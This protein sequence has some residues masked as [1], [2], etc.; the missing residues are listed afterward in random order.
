M[1]LTIHYTDGSSADWSYDED[2]SSFNGYSVSLDGNQYYA[3]PWQLGVNTVTVTY[4]GAETTFAVEVVESPVASIEVTKLPDKPW[5]I[6]NF[7][8]H[9][10]TRWDENLQEQVLFVILFSRRNGD[11]NHYTDGT[12]AIWNADD[13]L[14]YNGYY[15]S[16]GE[17]QYTTPGIGINTATVAYMG[18]QTTLD[19]VIETLSRTSK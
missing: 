16:I 14:F 12:S 1:E 7:N 10:D 8:G 18:A 2:G 13:G 15:I 17:N 3:S 5:A 19:E 6:E 9:W 11:E 4:M